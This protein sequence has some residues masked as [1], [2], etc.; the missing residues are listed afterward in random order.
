M[1]DYNI[2][3][4][5]IGTGGATNDNPTIPWSQKEGGGAFSQTVSQSGG[6]A[7]GGNF[8]R[9]VA[10]AQNPDAIVSSSIGRYGRALAVVGAAYA[11]LKLTQTLQDHIIGF[12][13]AENG[14]QLA[15]IRMEDTRQAFNNLI[16]PVSAI[17]QNIKIEKQWQRENYKLQ[18]QRDLLGDSII[19]SYTNKGV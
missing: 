15:R 1:A 17:I 18:Q 11:C 9:A 13:E 8:M 14:S 2:Y 10:F 16:R 7:G 19:N 3:L 12:A 4:H 6:F 5:A